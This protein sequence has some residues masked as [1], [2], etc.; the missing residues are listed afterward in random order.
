MSRAGCDMDG[1]LNILT[2]TTALAA[3]G[4]V[5]MCVYQDST[6]LLQR[7]HRVQ[8]LYE[9]DGKQHAALEDAGARVDGPV[10]FGFD[11]RHALRD[12][13]RFWPAAKLVRRSRANV[14]WLNRPEHIIW[15]QVV[16][17]F[18][19]IPIVCHLHHAPNFRWTRLL[20]VGV[21]HFIAVSR[22]ERERWIDRG[23]RQERITVLHNAILATDY[24]VGGREEQHDARQV[25]GI[26]RDVRVVLFC[27]R[28][29]AGKGILTLIEAWQRLNYAPGR[30]LLVLA[31]PLDATEAPA[32]EHALAGLT[33][34]SYRMFPLQS[35]VL[36][37][38]HAADIIVV[39][40]LD[41]EPFGRIVIE[42]M[43][44]GRPVIASRSG[45]IAE[46]LFGTMERFLATPGAVMEF[47]AQIDALLDWRRT[48]PLLGA[49][50]HAWVE[51][52]FPHAEH[53]NSLEQLLQRYGRIRKPSRLARSRRTSKLVG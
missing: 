51:E 46:I 47:A 5:E 4:G 39:P 6:A 18:A 34:G 44:T 24:P 12:L 7:G 32:V 17:R 52:N 36:P 3:V 10:R 28:I 33:P 19:G 9:L 49:A 22:F 30:A 14:L 41:P 2:A 8:V 11:P 20:N 40:S 15:A 35:Q 42:G 26:D 23:I 37:F 13:G 31:G 16:A 1:N 43:A 27:G 53:V 25:L 50:C 48:E 29:T 38:L 21:A 45:G